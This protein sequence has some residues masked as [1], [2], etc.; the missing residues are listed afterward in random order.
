[1]RLLV[2]IACAKALRQAELFFLFLFLFFDE[3][4]KYQCNGPWRARQSQ[5]KLQSNTRMAIFGEVSKI[6]NSLSDKNNTTTWG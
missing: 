4:M 5:Q 1:M 3:L 6:E 2:E